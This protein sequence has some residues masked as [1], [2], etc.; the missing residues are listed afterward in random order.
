VYHAGASGELVEAYDE[1]V[2]AWLARQATS[3]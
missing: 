3:Q 2:C 1:D